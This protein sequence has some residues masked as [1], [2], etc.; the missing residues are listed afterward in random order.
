MQYYIILYCPIASKIE[1]SAK[2]NFDITFY[3]LKSIMVYQLKMVYVYQSIMLN[4]I[5]ITI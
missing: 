1:N 4:L 3:T 2:I 5:K